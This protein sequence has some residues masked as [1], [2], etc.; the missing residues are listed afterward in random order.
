MTESLQ[1]NKKTN[2][3]YDKNLLKRWAWRYNRYLAGE[4]KGAD[5]SES[6][7]DGF[8]LLLRS[9]EGQQVKGFAE[10]NMLIKR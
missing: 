5:G 2:V 7:S 6:S 4:V 10:K 1:G 9:V 3:T 8:V